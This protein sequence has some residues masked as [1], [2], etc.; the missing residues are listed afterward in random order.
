MLV[1]REEQLVQKEAIKGGLQ[2]IREEQ[3][4]QKETKKSSQQLSKEAKPYLKQP[5][6]K[7]KTKNC[8]S[9]NEQKKD[10]RKRLPQLKTAAKQNSKND[11]RQL[12]I[13]TQYQPRSRYKL[14]KVPEIRLV[15]KWLREL[16]FTEGNFVELQL[17]QNKI[18]I[19]RC[20]PKS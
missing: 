15:G 7:T 16:G 12:K 8:S 4:V 19:T 13:A 20:I 11:I 17:K 10:S 2:V 5:T 9:D 18:T 3:L 14:I 6:K 1:I